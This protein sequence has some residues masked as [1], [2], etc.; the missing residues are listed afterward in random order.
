MPAG[1]DRALGQV[2]FPSSANCFPRVDVRFAKCGLGYEP[3]SKRRRG[4]RSFGWTVLAMGVAPVASGVLATFDPTTLPNGLY[5]IR[6][7]AVDVLGTEVST[8]VSVRVTEGPKIGHFTL[9]FTDLEIPVSGLPISI[10][11]SYDSR[12]GDVGDFGAS[13]KMDVGSVRLE[14][15]CIMCYALF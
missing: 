8:S 6:L 2:D 5:E 10:T 3:F 9:A 12:D 1:T 14:K 15:S 7:R 13:W 4:G 11:R